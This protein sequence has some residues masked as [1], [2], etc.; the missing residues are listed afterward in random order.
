MLFSKRR[1]EAKKSNKSERVLRFLFMIQS[2]ASELHVQP[3]LS[4][5]EAATCFMAET[6]RGYVQE[7]VL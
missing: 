2:F 7:T 1:N 6:G 4:V 3:P 5:L